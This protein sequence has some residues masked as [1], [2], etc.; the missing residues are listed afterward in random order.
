[1]LTK[2][3]LLKDRASLITQLESV[4]RLLSTRFDWGR[5]AKE[6]PEEYKIAFTSVA[7]PRKSRR[8]S[9]P[10]AKLS[11]EWYNELVSEG[12]RTVKVSDFRK[13]LKKRGY[14]STQTPVI[15][16]RAEGKLL[17]FT[18]GRGRRPSVFSVNHS[19][20]VRRVKEP[21]KLSSNLAFEWY[22]DAKRKGIHTITTPDYCKWL[23]DNGHPSNIH[24]VGYH[25]NKLIKEGKLNQITEGR[26]SR[27]SVFRIC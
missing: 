16:L 7:K 17:L 12:T 27:A 4:E 19:P 23:K 20:S 25:L 8:G 11:Q 18:Q 26:G 1:M 15:K 13:W 2:E 21:K 24:S 9:I 6:V 3:I 22:N 14:K 10:Y 5:P